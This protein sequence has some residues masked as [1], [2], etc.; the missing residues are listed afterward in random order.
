MTTGIGVKTTTRTASED[1]IVPL[2][3]N[4]FANFIIGLTKGRFATFEAITVPD[5]NKTGNPYYGNVVKIARAQVQWNVDY[6][7][8]M[9]AARERQGLDRRDVQPR[10]WGVHLDGTPYIFH[11]G[12]DGIP[13]LYVPMN[14]KRSL[15]YAYIDKRTNEEVGKELVNPFL[16][17][18]NGETELTWREYNI[19]TITK[20]TADGKTYAISHDFGLTPDQ[21]VKANEA[22]AKANEERKAEALKK[23]VAEKEAAEAK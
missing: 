2:T 16:R 14:I 3:F 22:L 20:I 7:K 1:G 19:G 11:V 21:L 15:G 23:K 13:K 4:E 10:K 5:M 12:K 9:N 6:G 18:R 8:S 17:K